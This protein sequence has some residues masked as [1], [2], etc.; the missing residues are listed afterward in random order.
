MHYLAVLHGLAAV[1]AASLLFWLFGVPVGVAVL[2]I[3]VAWIA[4]YF[5]SYGQPFVELVSFIAGMVSCPK[6]VLITLF[7]NRATLDASVIEC[8]DPNENGSLDYRCLPC[9]PFLLVDS[10]A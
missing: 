1:M 5:I 4:F 2:I 9:C 6:R 7:V 3:L 10:C 8:R